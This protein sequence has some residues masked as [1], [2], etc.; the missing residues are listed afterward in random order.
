MLTTSFIGAKIVL[1]YNQLSNNQL[2]IN[3]KNLVRPPTLTSAVSD[4][5]R[6]AILRGDYLPGDPLHEVE[7]GKSFDISRGTVREALRQLQQEGLV[8]VFPHRGAFVTLLSSQKVKEIY[9]LRALLEPYAV[10]L[11]IESKA[12]QPS[13]IAELQYLVKRLGELDGQSVDPELINTDMRFHR[14]MCERCGHQLLLEVLNNLQ[15]LT[16]LFI[17]N[18]KLYHSDLERDEAT[19]AEILEGIQS[20]DPQ[21]A[22][23]ILRNHLVDAGTSL[24]AR[25]QAN[26]QEL[27]KEQS[28]S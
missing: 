5:I 13:D 2:H 3:M 20:N 7:L 17:L 14:L 4:A 6:Q 9:T 22:E 15:S 23:G 10:R 28:K 27:L 26:E 8:E 16:L 11:A 25:M 24:L 1:S 21:R 18:T 12:Y 19:H